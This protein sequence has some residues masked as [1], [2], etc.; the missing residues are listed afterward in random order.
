LL[1]SLGWV[2][3][4][5]S[6]AGTSWL[7]DPERFHAS[8][9]GQTSCLECHEG[10]ADQ[11][12]HP[13]PLNVTKDR[14][15]FFRPDQCLECHDSI[16]EDLGQGV[17]GSLK[18][19]D[20]GKYENCLSCHEPHFQTGLGDSEEDRFDPKRPVSA[21]CGAC[22]EAR[23]K[24]PALSPEDA[25]CMTCHGQVKADDPETRKR[26]NSLCFHCHGRSGTKAQAVTGSSVSLMDEGIHA[27]A[28]HGDLACTACHQGAAAFSHQSKTRVDCRSCH[29]PHDEKPAHDAHISVSCE[30]CHIKG[31]QPVRHAG[32]KE[33]IW[34]KLPLPDEGSLLHQME[35]FDGDRA[36]RRCH[37]PGNALGAAAMVLPP[38]G[39][40]CM[41]CHT[42]TFSAG[43]AVTVTALI[44]FLCGL[45][46]FAAY[47]TAGALHRRAGRNPLSGLF[48]RTE[49]SARPIFSARVIPIVRTL[50]WDVILQ[51]RLYRES[52]KRWAIHG[53]IFYPFVFRFF[54]GLLALAGSL[55]KP[56]WPAIWDMINK[57]LPLTG[58][59]FDLTGL[60][61][62]VGVVLAFIRGTVRRGA[63]P[64]GLPGQDRLALGLI[65]G[66]VTAGFILE[67]MRI[68][69]TGYPAGSGYSFIGYGIALMFSAPRGLTEVYG[70][71]WYI[72][73][74]LTGAFIAYIPFS[75]LL[76]IIIAPV[77]VAMN[78]V[79]HK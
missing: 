49:K 42:A 19:T 52:P 38:K 54:W 76:H 79:Y 75:R 28:S 25:A 24:L 4:G 39:V 65:G 41:P 16:M 67:G 29:L 14:N 61:M 68:A 53:L 18:V 57:N 63:R 26:I 17:H 64:S 45:A 73:A 69:L 35:M 48:I 8:V 34:E 11:D 47:L 78:A 46:L 9:H 20:Q 51:R 62:L 33:I 31:V 5:S 1:L 7:I 77:V 74:V 43:D 58:F 44:I 10:I 40:L 50:F 66:I 37:F 12:L 3:S 32:S 21:Q 59:L 30:A 70:F 56:Q 15:D 36:C 2:L 27:A 60:M 6:Y 55:W 71:M 22:H 23:S 13:D 72:H